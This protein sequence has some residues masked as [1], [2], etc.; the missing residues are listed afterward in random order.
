MKAAKCL[1]DRVAK[2]TGLHPVIRVFANVAGLSSMV[3]RAQWIRETNALRAFIVGFSDPALG[4]IDFVDVG[5]GR[6]KV[7]EKFRG[8]AFLTISLIQLPELVYADDF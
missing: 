3:V 8:Q 4:Q 1:H 5:S 2:E 7:A 6:D